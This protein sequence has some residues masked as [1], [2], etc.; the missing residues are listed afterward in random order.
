MLPCFISDISQVDYDL[1]L[2]KKDPTPFLKFS[3]V[4]YANQVTTP[5]LIL[6]GEADERVP[7]LE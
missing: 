2:Q 5:L 3:A 7:T 6:H 1:R 4:M